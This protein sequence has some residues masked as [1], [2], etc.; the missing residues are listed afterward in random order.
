M[1][2]LWITDLTSTEKLEVTFTEADLK[3]WTSVQTLIYQQFCPFH[4]SGDREEQVR[5]IYC[6]CERGAERERLLFQASIPSFKCGKEFSTHQFLLTQNA[7]KITLSG[8]NGCW[9]ILRTILRGFCPLVSE[10]NL[11]LMCVSL[12]LNTLC[13][14]ASLCLWLS[15]NLI[16]HSS[17]HIWHHSYFIATCS[18]NSNTEYFLKMPFCV[19]VI[20]LRNHY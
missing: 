5:L 12:S 4:L 6:E 18:L 17:V 15:C 10:Q 3:C 16:H 7:V 2:G 13:P 1:T 11:L 19:R 14:E 9:T 20:E 8:Y